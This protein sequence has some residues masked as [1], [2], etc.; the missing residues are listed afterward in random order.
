MIL[1]IGCEKLDK[2]GS[3]QIKKEKISGYIQ[4]GP[5]LN[6]TQISMYELDSKLAQTGKVFNVTITDNKGSFEIDNITLSS[7]FV[8]L[9]AD[10]FYYNEIAGA[11][12]SASLKLTALSDIT[13][14]STI[15]VNILTHLEKRRIE[16]LVKQ[17]KTFKEAKATAQKEILAIFGF[18]KDNMKPSESLDISSSG[19]DN[20]ILLAISLILQGS[21]S[22]GELSELLAT[23]SADIESDGVLS[24]QLKMNLRSSAIALNLDQINSYLLERF[25][26]IGVTNSIPDFS[27]FVDL[28]ISNLAQK[29]EIVVSNYIDKRDVSVSFPIVVSPNSA[30]TTITLE[31]GLTNAYGNSI[32]SVQSPVTSSHQVN[33]TIH[34]NNLLPGTTYHYR[35]KAENS[36]GVAYSDD[37]TFTT[38]PFYVSVGDSFQGGIV[39]YIFERNDPG[40]DENIQHGLIAASTD[41]IVQNGYVHPSGAPWYNGVDSITGATGT[42]LGT[43]LANTIA[44]IK[45]QGPP[46]SY[47]DIWGYT[48][49]QPYAAW[50]ARNYSGGGYTDWFLPSKDELYKLWVNRV[51]IGNFSEGLAND[52]SDMYWS[53]S[54]V[55][56][57]MSWKIK[58]KNCERYTDTKYTPGSVR[59]V[60]YF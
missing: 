54:E 9:S 12:S 15:N 1:F 32:P 16:Y 51:K 17:G 24:D 52:G 58:F 36:K 3:T 8:Y 43:G 39:A 18:T 40:Y 42:A 34:L 44:I 46:V 53:S 56:S 10:G 7:N 31:Y 47:K 2:T 27:K 30:L 5:F 41:Q 11:V 26:T 49:T 22:V 29:P 37:K 4:K 55:S 6:G 57:N 59:A 14:I 20:A 48:G 23:I 38:S 60:R 45:I 35:V 50:I 21:L 33:D 25:Q 28:F 13:D 19:D